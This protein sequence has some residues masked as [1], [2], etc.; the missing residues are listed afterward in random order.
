MKKLN[1]IFHKTE[2]AT[3]YEDENQHSLNKVHDEDQ[4]DVLEKLIKIQQELNDIIVDQN[5]RLGYKWF[6]LIGV[7]VVIGSINFFA[8]IPAVNYLFLSTKSASTLKD[9]LIK[10]SFI[11]ADANI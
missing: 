4:D 2:L 5:K 11:P 9:A 8:I 10:D 3:G 6:W 1:D 7:G